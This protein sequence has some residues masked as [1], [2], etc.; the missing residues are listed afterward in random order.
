[1][2]SFA[3]VDFYDE[4]VIDFVPLNWIKGDRCAWPVAA[5]KKLS[6]SHKKLRESADSKPEEGWHWY[7]VAILSICGKL[8]LSLSPVQIMNRIRFQFYILRLTNQSHELRMC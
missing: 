7:P 2:A 3:V 5:G 8:R 6:Q 4:E 1:M